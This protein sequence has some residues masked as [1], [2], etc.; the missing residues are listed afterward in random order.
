M[1][2]YS[3]EDLELCSRCHW[4]D[5]DPD[6]C[7]G[8]EPPMKKPFI[9]EGVSDCFF[10]PDSYWSRIPQEYKDRFNEDVKLRSERY[11]KK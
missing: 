6:L 3:W 2:D 9:P 11:Y 8:V 7:H 1:S 4:R 5:K 10:V